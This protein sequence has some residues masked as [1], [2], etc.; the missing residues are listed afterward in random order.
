MSLR[1]NAGVNNY[2][3]YVTGDMPV[4][5]YD[6]TRLSNVGI[7]HGA[8]DAG[9]GYTYFNQ[10]TGHEFSGVLGFTYNTT[11]QSDPISERRRRAF[12]LGR[13]SVPDQAVPD[14][15]RRVRL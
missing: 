1:W 4:G 10:K 9:F 15:R 2:M 5:A 13:V 7:G 6:S 3:V 8:V 11:N 12:R 14:R